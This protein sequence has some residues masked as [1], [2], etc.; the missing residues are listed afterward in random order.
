V[1]IYALVVQ[2]LLFAVA[3]SHL[4]QAS[5]FDDIALAQLCQ[6]Q[7]DG[8]PAAPADQQN[9][10]AHNR[11]L[12][13]FAGAFALDTPNPAVVS[14]VNR[15]VCKVLQSTAPQRLASSSQY[16]VARPRGPPLKA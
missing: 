4:A 5:A 11:C 8:S 6:H 2:P 16:L 13:C 15:D 9:D 7:T 1:A 10:P 12:L 14:V 3:G